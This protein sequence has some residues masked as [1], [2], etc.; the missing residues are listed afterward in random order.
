MARTMA[1]TKKLK[2][3]DA[4]GSQRVTHFFEPVPK[5]KQKRKQQSRDTDEVCNHKK[6]HKSKSDTAASIVTPAS[7]VAAA[8]KPAS[9]PGS[10]IAKNDESFASEN[11]DR[12][13]TAKKAAF[14]SIKQAPCK[15]D[16]PGS[17]VAKKDESFA[18]EN[19]DRKPTAKK[20][21]FNS[22]KQAP[23]KADN[24]VSLLLPLVVCVTPRTNEI[25][26]LKSVFVSPAQEFDPTTQCS[27]LHAWVNLSSAKIP[28]QQGFQKVLCAGSTILENCQRLRRHLAPCTGDIFGRGILNR[29]VGHTHAAQLRV[30]HPP[31]STNEIASKGERTF[32]LRQPSHSVEVTQF[33]TS[34][35][36][37][38]MPHSC[39]TVLSVAVLS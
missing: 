9:K 39:K 34:T 25:A 37:E 3:I 23:G 6:N 20:A 10:N 29:E 38:Q 26:A 17:N 4:E 5:Q 12:K 15:A 1:R 27:D 32:V 24:D 21:A 11:K 8:P 30:H 19:E 14:D 7:I 13:P 16:K 33:G 2:K 22:I 28:S 36:P 18:R 31:G 35:S